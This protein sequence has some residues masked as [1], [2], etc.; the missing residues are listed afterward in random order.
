[1]GQLLYIIK[2]YIITAEKVNMYEFDNRH[3][4]QDDSNMYSSSALVPSIS[5]KKT[6]AQTDHIILIII[7]L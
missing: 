5:G 7:Y 3:W 1:M 4:V 6:P 2:S